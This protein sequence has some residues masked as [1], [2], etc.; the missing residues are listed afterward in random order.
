MLDAGNDQTLSVFFTPT[1]TTDY[2]TA[3]ATATIDVDQATPSITWA[4]P[5][6]ITYGTALSTDQLDATASV[7]GMFTYTPALG[8][9]LHAG[10][11]QTLSVSFTPSDTS[12]YNSSSA[13]ATI[14]VDEATPSITWANPT[15]ITYGTALSSSQLDATA[16]VPGTFTYTLA[17]GTVLDAGNGQTLSVSFTP[18]DTTDYTTATAKATI[19]V[20]KATPSITWANPA[21]ITYGTALSTAQLDATASVPGT[22][23]YTRALG[24]VLHAGNDQTLSVSFTPTDTTDYT[25]A[26]AKATINVDKATPSITWAKPADIT[27][28]TALSSAQLDATASVPGSFSYTLGAGTFLNAGAGQ[29]LSAS[30]MPTD[31][32]DYNAAAPTSTINVDK[33]TPTL[34]V[35]A[36][37]G[38]YNGTPFPASVTI[39]G[40]TN[41]SETALEGVTPILAYYVGSSTSGISLGSTPPTQPGTYTVVAS[42]GGNTDYTSTRS[43]PATFTIGLGSATIAL[44]SPGGSAV[45]GQS[46]TFVATVKA[47]STPEGTVTFSDGGIPLATIPLGGSGQGTLAI[48]SLALGSHAVTATYSG[49]ADVLGV[50]S[51]ATDLSVHPDGTRVVLV[52]HAI[53]KKK[54]LVS[55]GLKAEIEPISPGGG[56]PTG[57]VTFELTKK[58]RKKLKVKTLGTIS[59]NGGAATLTLRPKQV[60]RKAIT[61]VYSGNDDFLASKLIPAKLTKKQLKRLA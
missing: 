30:F 38:A 52:P 28:G 59:V 36:P 13:T 4:N 11:D 7:P 34:N 44:T 56:L 60:L 9:V 22:F 29:V 53:F 6:D 27:Y 19:N 39:D 5:A 14:N 48:S 32:M 46:V 3:T 37:D 23:T 54:K 25:T 12:D 31:T 42:F 26:T 35:S 20:D 10:N 58:V 1:D 55:V 47:P 2:T 18:T 61:I 45:F 43:A 40:I 15:D 57:L 33:A 50:Q 17:L 21:D 49:D 41:S 16:S 24:S 8:A 51:S